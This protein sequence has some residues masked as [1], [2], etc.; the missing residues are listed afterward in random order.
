MVPPRGARRREGAGPR[1]A[2][3]SVLAA[4]RAEP[5]LVRGVL[6]EQA[7]RLRGALGRRRLLAEVGLR[8]ALRER[9]RRLLRQRLL[10]E[11]RR[12]AA[13]GW[14]RS[15]RRECA[16]RHGVQRQRQGARPDVRERIAQRTRAVVNRAGNH[17][18]ARVKHR[19]RHEVRARV[20]RVHQ[21]LGLREL[22]RGLF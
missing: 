1:R 18:L 17:G 20:V 10:A 21:L 7:V 22:D 4:A 13:C 5:A 3:A 19:R 2:R 15:V 9:Q 11:T 12:A 14:R 8:G 16:R 6:R